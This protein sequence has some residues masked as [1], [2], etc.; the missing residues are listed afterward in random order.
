MASEDEKEEGFNPRRRLCP[1][2]RCPVCGLADREGPGPTAEEQSLPESADLPEE[3][4]DD[5]ANDG[6][7]TGADFDPQRRLCSDGSCIGVIGGD[8]RCSVCGKPAEG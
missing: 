3:D 4:I 8:N 5:D 1:D 2:G 7:A 6:H